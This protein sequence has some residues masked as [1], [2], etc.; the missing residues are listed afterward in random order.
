MN[1]ALDNTLFVLLLAC[2]MT[3]G[4][5]NYLTP[6]HSDDYA[7]H[8]FGLAAH[9]HI[10]HYLRWSG[11]V[12]AD[13]ISPLLLSIPHP[14]V[15][16][17]VQTSG[18]FLLVLTLARAA[19][20]GSVQAGELSWQR[21]GRFQFLLVASVLLLMYV[22]FLPAFGQV[23]LWVVGSAN[24]MWMALLYS[25]YLYHMLAFYYGRPFARYAYPLALLAGCSN[26]SAAATL[27]LASLG[28]AAYCY[29]TGRRARFP[30]LLAV[31]TLFVLGAVVL[32]GAPGNQARLEDPAFEWFT[33]MSLGETV[34]RFILETL[35]EV[36][37]QLYP[38]YVVSLGLLVASLFFRRQEKTQIGIQLVFIFLSLTS[39]ASMVLSPSFSP[40]TMTVPF[41][42]N[43][44][45]IGTGV[46]CLAGMGGGRALKGA[47]GM[48]ACAAALAVL[49]M[50]VPGYRSLNDQ[51]HF[52]ESLIAAA[53]GGTVQIPAF[54]Y[55]PLPR[56]SLLIDAYVNVEAMA[57]F[58]GAE[59]IR[60][61]RP[62]FDYGLM[63][64]EGRREGVFIDSLRDEGIIVKQGDPAPG[65]IWK[66]EFS[67]GNGKTEV[68]YAYR[69][70]ILGEERYYYVTVPAS[71]QP[72]AGEVNFS[73]VRLQDFRAGQFVGKSDASAYGQL[74][75]FL[76]GRELIF[77]SSDCSAQ[78][79]SDPFFV[80][81]YPEDARVLQKMGAELPFVNRDFRFD[82]S[83]GYRE[84]SYC[85][86]VRELPRYSIRQINLGQFNAQGRSWF[87]VYAK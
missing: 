76:H 5:L 38:I 46:S 61:F 21:G 73:Q 65:V 40:R 49:L 16:S 34:Q 67:G 2:A 81:V 32:I 13:Y 36:F 45:A 22:L 17:L 11:R 10:A 74:S 42:L 86:V 77:V 15:L 75:V 68:A 9:M 14:A 53:D 6:M 4:Y 30:S 28:F 43:L 66:A 79:V 25:A 19:T 33:A 83:K 23:N 26:E 60:E 31:C 56:K 62:D 71:A 24:Y 18:M 59:S 39:I 44:V 27:S 37:A 78:R 8:N 47:L 84:G 55:P 52:R 50:A 20:L 72:E 58:Y 7:F 82:E 29:L 80:H 64:R 48:L 51:H 35:P 12:V 57:E 70:L 1:R 85:F 3:V 41:V 69:Y 54:H 87:L 63:Q